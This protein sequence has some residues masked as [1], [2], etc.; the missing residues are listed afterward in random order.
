MFKER[1]SM[2]QTGQGNNLNDSESHFGML[3]KHRRSN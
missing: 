2:M 1:R 3:H